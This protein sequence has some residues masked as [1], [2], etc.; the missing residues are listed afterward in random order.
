[1]V[2]SVTTPAAGKKITFDDDWLIITIPS[3]LHTGPLV[4]LLTHHILFHY[5]Y[6]FVLVVLLLPLLITHT[7]S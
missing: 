2:I 7:F 1:V 3:V 4:T 5:Y 6:C